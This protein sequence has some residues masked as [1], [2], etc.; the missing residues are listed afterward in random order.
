[1]DLLIDLSEALDVTLDYLVKGISANSV[2]AKNLIGQMFFLLM[3]M[4]K[5][6]EKAD[7]QS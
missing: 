1:M 7:C 5:V 3:Q 6:L 4:E 2:G